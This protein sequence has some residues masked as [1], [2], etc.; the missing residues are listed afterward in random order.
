MD[1]INALA[2]LFAQFPGIGSRQSRRFVYFLLKQNKAYVNELVRQI[3][4]LENSVYECARCHA[5]F[6]KKHADATRCSRCSDSSR[7]KELLLLVERDSDL[8]A[9]ERSG[10]YHG[11][12]FVL[13]GTLSI[14]EKDPDTKIR[15]KE[16]RSLLKDEAST[17]N[18]IIFAHAMNPE[19]EHTFDHVRNSISDLAA[20][21]GIRITSLGRGLSTGTELEYSD[22]DTLRWA[23]EGRK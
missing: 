5:Y 18:E 13:G 16:L 1:N 15:L 9:V 4:E 22:A 20:A 6:M 11:T 19:G 12:Y 7:D 14:L 10:V 8:D 3:K 17:I 23:L 21:Q 2:Q